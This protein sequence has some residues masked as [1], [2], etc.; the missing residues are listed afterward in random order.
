MTYLLHRLAFVV[1]LTMGAAAALS[2]LG[3]T[4]ADTATGLPHSTA[5][6]VVGMAH[7]AA[8]VLVTA[9]P[10]TPAACALRSHGGWKLD[11]SDAAGAPRRL[12]SE[13]YR[14]T[15]LYTLLRVYRL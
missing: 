15:P 9:R 1:A 11:A 2:A 10:R 13:P 7:Q 12:A 14:T 3:T 8:T 5:S 4:S 6:D